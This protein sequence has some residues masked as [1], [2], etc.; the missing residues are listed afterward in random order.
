V[1]ATL[2]VIQKLC[3][4]PDGINTHAYRCDAEIVP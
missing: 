2:L 3:T 4:L 1:L